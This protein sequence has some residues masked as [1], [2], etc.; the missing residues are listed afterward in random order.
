M[1]D[2]SAFSQLTALSGPLDL[3]ASH[4]SLSPIGGAWFV[5]TGATSAMVYVQQIRALTRL[6]VAWV[7]TG[8]L[9]L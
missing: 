5:K 4:Y 3:L 6:F 2:A 8:E 9:G 7:S 1:V